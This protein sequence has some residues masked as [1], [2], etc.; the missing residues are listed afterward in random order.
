MFYRQN[1]L[2]SIKE[3]CVYNAAVIFDKAT[4]MKSQYKGIA[5]EFLMVRIRSVLDL[6]MDVLQL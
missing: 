6:K 4:G 2:I 1:L 5:K 3:I